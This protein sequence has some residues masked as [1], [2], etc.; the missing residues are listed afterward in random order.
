MTSPGTT[1]SI[2]AI[3]GSTSRSGPI[4]ASTA[5]SA[6]PTIPISTIAPGD[7]IHCDTGIKYLRWNSDHQHVAYVPKLGETDAP[8]GLKQRLADNVRLQDVYM[9]EFRHG[10]SGNDLQQ[11]VLMRARA[12]G[13]PEPMIYSHNLGLFLHQPGPLIGLP[14]EQVNPLP[15]GEI[16]LEYN[17]AFV[18]E[19]STTGPVPEW[20]NQMLRLGT[21]EP[22]IFTTRGLPDPDRTP[23]RISRDLGGLRYGPDEE[24]RE[25][26]DRQTGMKE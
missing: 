18:M 21:E 8:A 12:E 20:D 16:S 5:T 15:R 24:T 9:S 19:L 25:Q 1:G 4:S 2:R 7:V 10:I 17:S 11:N 6:T 13:I 23:D 14:W 22:V 26:R 3:S